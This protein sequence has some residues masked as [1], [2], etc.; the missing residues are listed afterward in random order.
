M[1]VMVA[2]AK[3]L[4]HGLEDARS[5]R[6]GNRDAADVDVG[7]VHSR[8]GSVE[9]ADLAGGRWVKSVSDFRILTQPC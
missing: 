7:T 8:T 9:S 5:G 2:V 4:V 1:A 3:N 6:A